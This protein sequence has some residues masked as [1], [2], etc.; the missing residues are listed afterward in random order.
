MFQYMMVSSA[1]S[2]MFDVIP[3]ETGWGRGQTLVGPQMS[4]AHFL[5]PAVQHYLLATVF[6]EVLDSVPCLAFYVVPTQFVEEA[7]VGHFI[8][9][10]REI[11]HYSINLLALGCVGVELLYKLDEFGFAGQSFSESVLVGVQDA[12]PVKVFTYLADHDMFH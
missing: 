4:R 3:S 12:V 2:L 6:Q 10:L 8:E 9:R 7:V 5:G 1:K 11:H